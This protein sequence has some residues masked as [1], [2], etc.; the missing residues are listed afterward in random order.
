MRHIALLAMALMAGA[1]GGISRADEPAS[2]RANQFAAELYGQASSENPTGN[3]FCSPMSVYGALMMTRAGAAGTTAAEMDSALHAPGGDAQA[4]VGKLL[5]DSASPSGG[6][7]VCRIASALWAQ[8]GMQCLPAF[9]DVLSRDYHSDFFSVDFNNPTDASRVINEWVSGRTEGKIPQLF[10]PGAL[11]RGAK[12]VLGN[13]IYFYADWDQPFRVEAS[14]L[15]DFH[16]PGQTDPVQRMMMHK[17]AG[18]G[19]MKGDG[20]TALELLYKGKDTSMLILLP[21]KVDGIKDLESKFSDRMLSDVASHL[22]VQPTAITIPK[23]KYSQ[24]LSLTETLKRMGIRQA[25]E[26]EGADFSG[27]DGKRDLFLSNVVHKAYVSVDEKGTEAAAATGAVMMPTAMPVLGTEFVADHP[28]MFLIRS[29]VTGAVLFVG[30]VWDP[31][32]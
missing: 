30:R 11:P 25:F 9:R 12:M 1:A 27:I 29:R 20:F 24:E 14:A 15:R 8:N 23:F 4:A 13:A 16:V 5:D 2:A 7:F 31:G 17:R 26:A 3:L 22:Q 19:L 32:N 10:S 18:A 28:F 21:D 6:N